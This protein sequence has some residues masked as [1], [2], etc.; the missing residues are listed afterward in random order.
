MHALATWIHNDSNTPGQNLGALYYAYWDGYQWLGPSVAASSGSRLLSGPVVA[1]AAPNE[2]VAVLAS[3]VPNN[4]KPDTA[5]MFKAQMATQQ[6]ATL[7]FDGTTWSGPTP[8]T[9]GGGARGRVVLA[10]APAYGRAIAMWVHDAGSGGSHKWEV[11]YSVYS[12]ATHTWSMP[13]VVSPGQPAN[14]LDAEITLAFDSWGRAMASWVRQGNANFAD[15]AH[16]SLVVA[17][18]NAVSDYWTVETPAELPKGVLMPAIGFDE[19]TPVLAYTTY[20]LGPSGGLGNP[21]GLSV[22]TYDGSIWQAQPVPG[23]G[24]TERPQV[25]ALGEHQML[26]TYR[27]YGVGAGEDFYGTLMGAIADLSNPGHPKVTRGLRHSKPV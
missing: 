22:A 13:K 21:T 9:Y 20:S 23:T 16:R 19:G 1:Y 15:N 5:D 11:E 7:R 26:I 18:W 25:L 6:I 3:N 14:S 4:S 27:Q 24:Q 17:K 12:A 8:L 10:G 2:A